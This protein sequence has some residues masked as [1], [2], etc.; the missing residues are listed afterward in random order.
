M[1][2]TRK[3]GGGR[4]VFS[5]KPGSLTEGS[6]RRGAPVKK[7][8]VKRVVMRIEAFGHGVSAVMKHGSGPGGEWRRGKGGEKGNKRTY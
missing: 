1:G 3:E 7:R 4:P 6:L 5:E 8:R 2:S